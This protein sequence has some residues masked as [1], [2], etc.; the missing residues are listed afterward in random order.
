MH[1]SSNVQG[2]TCQKRGVWIKETFKEAVVLTSKGSNYVLGLQV[3]EILTLCCGRRQ[4]TLTASL[5]KID[6]PFLQETSTIHSFS[7]R[8]GALWAP[9]PSMLVF[10]LAWSCP[11]LVSAVIAAVSSLVTFSILPSSHCRLHFPKLWHCW[12]TQNHILKENWL[13][14]LQKPAAVPSSLVRGGKG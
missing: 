8:G 9:P 4:M 3:Q 14:F 13:F 5:K 6:P 12:S 10:C 7:A 1:R 2:I 11:G